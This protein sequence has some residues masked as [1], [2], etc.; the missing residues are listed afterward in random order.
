MAFS[1]GSRQCLG[2]EL[3]K[4]ELY[5]GIAGVFRRFGGRM[6]VVDTVHERDLEISHDTFTPTARKKSKGMMIEILEWGRQDFVEWS[7]S[8]ASGPY[9]S[10]LL[11]CKVFFSYIDFITLYV[12]IP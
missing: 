8:V 10:V 7:E 5:M 3:G 12:H 11:T 1:R 4:A 2:I 9:Q 6:K